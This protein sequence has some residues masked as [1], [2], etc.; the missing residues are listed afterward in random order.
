MSL[1]TTVVDVDDGQGVLLT[2]RL[3][4]CICQLSMK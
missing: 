2:V 4:G 3:C 1:S